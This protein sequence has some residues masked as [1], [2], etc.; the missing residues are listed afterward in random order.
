MTARPAHGFRVFTI[1]WFGQL[2]STLGSGLT[3]FALGIWIYE[4]TGSETLFALNM[5][6][7]VLP[8]IIL[9]PVAGVIADRWDRRLVMMLGDSLAAAG[10]LFIVMMMLTGHLQVWHIYV[11]VFL[12]SMASTFQ[13]PAYSAATTLLVPKEHLGRAGGMTQIAQAVSQLITPAIAGALY[14]TA[15]LWA[16]ILIDLAGYAFALLTLLVVRFPQPEA[17]AEGAAGRGSFWKE[18]MFGWQYIR[19]RPGL[20]GLLIVFALTNFMGSVTSPLMT[21]LLLDMASPDVVGYVFSISGVGMLIG[22]LVM[23]AWGG[24][25]RRIFGI[26]AFDMLGGLSFMLFGLRPSVVLITIAAFVGLFSMPITNGCSQALWQSKV[27]QDVQGRVFAARRMIAYSI[28]PLAFVVAGPLAE[29][30]FEPLLVEG[31]PLAASV[32][33]VIGVGAGRGTGLLFVIAGALYM[34]VTL[35]I[36]IHPRI[37][38]VE[39][40]LPDAVPSA[41]EGEVGAPAPVQA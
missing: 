5:L 32:G 26:A 36:V 34:L 40:E 35:V 3:G 18:A 30:V 24:P 37:R 9:S 22:T 2:I 4:T 17:T 33:R 39:L 8:N 41:S 29:H 10:T 16:I 19:L 20:F 13:W 38:R 14:V 27:A 6:A 1:I 21:P 28:M 11:A 7:W 31:G 23:S 15:G 12:D 25:K